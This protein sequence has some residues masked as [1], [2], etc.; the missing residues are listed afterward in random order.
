MSHDDFN[1]NP[2]E[3]KAWLPNTRSNSWESELDAVRKNSTIDR[4]LLLSSESINQNLIQQ[5]IEV[6]EAPRNPSKAK[7]DTK[8]YPYP[9]LDEDPS[10]DSDPNS[11][12]LD[13]TS[14]YKEVLQIAR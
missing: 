8:I 13:R 9:V 11:S 4:L 2:F 10:S 12:E 3:T 14:S 6:P 7:K 5:S 1:D